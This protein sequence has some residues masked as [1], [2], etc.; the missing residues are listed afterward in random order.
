MLEEALAAPGCV[1][2]Q[3]ALD[4]DAYAALARRLRAAPG[5]GLLTLARGSSDHAAHHLA[6]LVMAR[7]G[8]LVT[9]LPM[10][11][12]TLH[13]GRIA[14]PNLVSFAFSQSGQSPD[15]IEPTRAFRAA[16]ACTVALVNAEGSPL[17]AAAEHVLP[18][19]AGPEQSVAATKS[20]IAQL[21]AG[22]RLVAAW[23][24]DAT[25]GAALQQLPQALE[26]AA[27]LR[28]QAAVEQLQ[29]AEQLFVIGRGL[30][31]AVAQEAALKF[32]ETCGMQA[33]AFS[34]AEVQ[35]GPMA[36]VGE[37]WPLL[38]LA[39]RG[40]AQAGLVEL[41]QR[42]HARGARVLL[43][44]PAATPGTEGLTT[45][46]LATTAHEDLDAIAAVQSF[47]PMVEAL[48]RARGRD[49]DRPPFLAKV[50]QTH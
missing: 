5:H 15:L 49:P 36:L 28:W 6:Y 9:S 13:K 26:Q 18:L 41:A 40:P 34:G 39:P 3:L 35:H 12:V 31:L 46:P 11:L 8:R 38:V 22:A 42:L 16:G 30:G 24:A 29:N 37:G 10:S 17:A 44:V 33:E 2:Q 50:T 47:Y 48:A 25:F 45:L 23:E 19:H 1:A 21:V 14:A 27:A 43:A 32:K 4:A 20:Y 7:L